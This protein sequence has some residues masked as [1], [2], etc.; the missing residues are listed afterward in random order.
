MYT[1]TESSA[2]VKEEKKYI[3]TREKRNA[4][5]SIKIIKRDFFD[6]LPRS[7]V[8]V[9]DSI[10]W[11]WKNYDWFEEAWNKYREHVIEATTKGTKI[12][13]PGFIFNSYIDKQV[14]ENFLDDE[15]RSLVHSDSDLDE[16]FH[17]GVKGQ[18]WGVRKEIENANERTPSEK[19]EHLLG[20]SSGALIGAGIG[21][22][23]SRKKYF[24]SGNSYK[25]AVQKTALRTIGMSIVGGLLGHLI[26]TG[27]QRY[28]RDNS[29]E[30]AD[31]LKVKAAR[32]IR[33][34]PITN[35]LGN[36]SRK[37]GKKA[38]RIEKAGQ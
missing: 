1:D 20:I 2:Y 38:Y 37:L 10:S 14:E 5:A 34:N 26:T 12:K 18:K 21:Y 8:D 19:K 16:L 13:A 35:P 23:S 3:I 15:K 30:G 6:D 25:E 29:L 31:K 36:I 7:V 24:K 33:T 27:K 28:V 4:E 22:L 11:N 9:L 17:H 32:T